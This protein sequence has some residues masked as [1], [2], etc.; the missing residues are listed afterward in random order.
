MRRSSA[1]WAS[2][3][4]I[5]TRLAVAIGRHCPA[6]CGFELSRLI[7]LCVMNRPGG[8][9]NNPPHEPH[10]R[11]P[12]CRCGRPGRWP[13]HPSALDAHHALAQR[14]GRGDPG[15]QRLAHLQRV[16]VLSVR[17]SR[18]ASRSAAG[19]AARCSGTLR[20]C[21]CWCS[22][23]WCTWRSTSSAAG[24]TRKFFPL[25]P[26]GLLHDVLAALQGKLSHADPRHYNNVQKLAYLFVMLDI[27]RA[28][29]VGPGAVEVGAV[30]RAARSA[31]RLRVCASHPL[32]RHG[33]ARCLS[34][35]ST[36]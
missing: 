31:G 24:W 13:A 19:W 36:S 6:I 26:R 27:D 2:S 32:L 21:G 8:A 7:E 22:T 25:S 18:P 4:T 34:S 35:S 17:H 29:A 20:R 5:S 3:S 23:A 9:P 10:R 33:R 16:A 14:P 15:D 28:R 11:R 30:P 12:C 1:M